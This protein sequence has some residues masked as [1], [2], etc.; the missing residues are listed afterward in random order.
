M[1]R[2]LSMET[3]RIVVIVFVI[4]LSLYIV[5]KL[6][7]AMD[8]YGRTSVK[9]KYIMASPFAALLDSYTKA[10]STLEYAK[11]VGSAALIGGL[12]VLSCLLT[13]KSVKLP[14]CEKVLKYYSKFKLSSDLGKLSKTEIDRD[15]R[16][17]IYQTSEGKIGAIELQKVLPSKGET[18]KKI[19]KSKYT[20]YGLVGAGLIGFVYSTDYLR[21]IRNSLVDIISGILGSIETEVDFIWYVY[22]N[23]TQKYVPIVPKNFCNY[24][25]GH[26]FPEAYLILKKKYGDCN[27]DNEKWIE[28]YFS[29]FIANR[30]IYTF[31]ESL[32]G[33]GGSGAGIPVTH[34][35]VLVY[36]PEDINNIYESDILC[37]WAVMRSKKD[38]KISILE[39]IYG[40]LDD[41]Y[42]KEYVSTKG[43]NICGI[44]GI[45]ISNMIATDINEG[46][47]II[48]ISGI[49]NGDSTKEGYI[50]FEEFE[51]KEEDVILEIDFIN[52][53]TGGVII[54]Y[55][56]I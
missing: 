41:P 38:E 54:S 30:A 51:K 45:N 39:E 19:V 23:N 21:S 50:P 8:Y 33:L 42:S 16:Y 35:V 55:F 1:K 11:Y 20:R 6:V 13:D 2:A 10:D 29:F 56:P 26:L 37:W 3:L 24:M 49:V 12:Y 34:Y 14:F 40:P 32:Y 5:F 7:S 46:V 48:Y 9:V 47:D 52:E 43:K 28:L 22:N 17:I 4:A 27:I 36:Q 53:G 31:S 25:K 15:T 18:V 44:F